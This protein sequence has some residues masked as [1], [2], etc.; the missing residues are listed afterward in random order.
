MAMTGTTFLLLLGLAAVAGLTECVRMLPRFAG[1]GGGRMAARAGLV[2]AAQLG[3]LLA[4]SATVNA[5]FNF[6]ASWSDLLGQENGPVRVIDR[7]AHPGPTVTPLTVSPEKVRVRA[8]HVDKVM[9]GGP[10]TGLTATAYV[11]TPPEYQAARARVLPAVLVL[12]ADP[13]RTV[14]TLRP[15]AAVFVV[16]SPGQCVD[17]VGGAKAEG[18]LSQDV[19]TDIAASYR[20]GRWGV[21]GDSCGARLVLRHSD[22]FAAAIVTSGSYD[23]PS[24]NLYGGSPA[25]RAENDLY[26]RLAHSAQPPAALLL[27]Y[28]VQ[29]VRLAGLAR[30]PLNIELSKGPA[31]DPSVALHWLL[32]RIK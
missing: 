27:S 5:Y 3:L 11:Y 8:G 4:L 9:L 24:G 13:L 32:G 10:R 6:Y 28:N 26:W 7:P 31:P 18:F 17:A 30:P 22:R 2:V 16:M 19:P 25:I 12:V 14:T 21:L 23:T 29:A 1:P 20:V 15:A